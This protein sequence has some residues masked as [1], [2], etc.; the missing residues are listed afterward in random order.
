MTVC[1]KVPG[2][3]VPG[4]VELDPGESTKQSVKVMAE[5]GVV[6]I[7]GKVNTRRD[8]SPNYQSSRFMSLTRNHYVSIHGYIQ[9][10]SPDSV[11]R[12]L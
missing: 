10:E 11:W 1:H 5:I 3:P 4:A 9:E 6:K 7:L 12:R 8:R 2:H